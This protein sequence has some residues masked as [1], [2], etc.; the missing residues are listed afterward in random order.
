MVFWKRPCMYIYVIVYW[1]YY[2]E[3][4]KFYVDKVIS[5]SLNIHMYRYTAKV[6]DCCGAECI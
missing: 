3:A 6:G 2:C 1:N 5:L 4:F